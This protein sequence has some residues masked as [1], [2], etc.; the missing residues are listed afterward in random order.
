MDSLGLHRPMARKLDNSTESL[1]RYSESKHKK[2]HEW[3][4]QEVEDQ[5]IKKIIIKRNK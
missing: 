3:R 1:M 5:K 4:D 2:E